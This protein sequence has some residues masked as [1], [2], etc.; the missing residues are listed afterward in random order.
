V[1]ASG[2]RCFDPFLT[3]LENWLD[4][5]ANYFCKR[6][7]SAF[8]EGL[9]NKIKVLKRRCFG[10]VNPDHLFQRLTLDLEGYQRFRSWQG[11]H[12]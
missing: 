2:L 5:I 6:Q 10:L 11:T 1:I 7:T 3:L 4:R 12:H 8:V 9:N